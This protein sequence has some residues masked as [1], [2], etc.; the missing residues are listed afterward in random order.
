MTVAPLFPGHRPDVAGAIPATPRKPDRDFA[1]HVAHREEAQTSRARLEESR[2]PAPD[3]VLASE[4]ALTTKA[5]I[6]PLAEITNGSVV[7]PQS[8]RVVGYLSMLAR[9]DDSAHAAE[10]NVA[11]TSDDETTATGTPVPDSVS[12]VMPRQTVGNGIP[13]VAAGP[14]SRVAIE[15]CDAAPAAEVLAMAS[16]EGRRFARRFVRLS[17]GTLLLRDFSLGPDRARA[18]LDAFRTLAAIDGRPLT[19]ATINGQSYSPDKEDDHVG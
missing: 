13:A 12:D 4:K 10:A 14:G 9:S 16:P 3:P 17:G 19:R 2:E 5:V 8:L 1:R 18:V 15:T 11:G 6:T 7:Y